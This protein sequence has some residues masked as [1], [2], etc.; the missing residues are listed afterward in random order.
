MNLSRG[1]KIT[2]QG[3]CDGLLAPEIAAREGWSANVPHTYAHRVKRK[4]RCRTRMQAVARFAAAKALG[5]V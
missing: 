3:F 5:F 2:M 1:E 4:L